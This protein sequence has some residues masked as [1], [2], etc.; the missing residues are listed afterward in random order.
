MKGSRT[1]HKVGHGPDGMAV[2]QREIAFKLQV[3]SREAVLE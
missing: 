1:H 3:V 2:G